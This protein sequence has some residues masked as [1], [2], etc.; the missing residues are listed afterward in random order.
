MFCSTSVIVALLQNF[1]V[2]EK[3][4]NSETGLCTLSEQISVQ[5]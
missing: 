4:S 1:H 3:L 2:S 5:L